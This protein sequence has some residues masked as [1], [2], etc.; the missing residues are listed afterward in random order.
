MSKKSKKDKF[1]V[2]LLT[3]LNN[4]IKQLVDHQMPGG[5]RSRLLRLK[6]SWIERFLENGSCGFSVGTTRQSL[7]KEGHCYSIYRNDSSGIPDFTSEF[8]RVV[9]FN[10][11]DN[12][13]ED[14]LLANRIEI[15]NHVSIATNHSATLVVSRIE[16]CASPLEQL[17]NVAE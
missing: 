2:E 14:Q 1:L 3:E 11:G 15:V 16:A 6:A 9:V 17:A 13:P 7:E 8:G 12:W 5:S 10:E 4:S